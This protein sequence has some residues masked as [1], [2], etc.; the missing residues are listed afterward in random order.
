MPAVPS[1]LFDA[2]AGRR[3][4]GAPVGLLSALRAVPDPRARRGRRYECAALLAVA[5]AAVL[6][7]ARSFCAIGEWA[8]DA[9]LEVLG[10]LGVGDTAPDEKTIRVVCEAVDATALA[11]AMAGW[12]GN[13]ARR[14]G[15]RRVI[16]VDGKT[17]RGARVKDT[18]T[19]HL[20]AAFEHTS[21]IVV[22]QVQVDGK[23]NEI[24]SFAPLLDRV[25]IA[26]TV[27]TADALHTQ[28]AHAEYLHDRGADWLLTVKNNRP[29]LRAELAAL[30]WDE[31]DIAAK[32]FD[33]GH[34]RQEQRLLK[35]V[36]VSRGISFPHAAQAIQVIRRT[37]P[38]AGG[39]WHT[40]TVYAITSMTAERVQGSELNA[41]LRRHWAVENELHWV[42]DVTF[43]EDASRVRTGE[44]P[45]VMATLRNLAISL[46][47][48]LGQANVAAW[49]RR[50][51]RN[52]ARPIAALNTS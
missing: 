11:S 44:G 41:I 36:T 19:P 27:V 17:T 21:G 35:V 40:E 2:L 50:N 51:A 34:G 38:L 46:A 33:R 42:R 28:N 37:R 52:A 23:S 31:V 9:P 4:A 32:S 24:T 43:G 49:L 48:L 16:A 6:A 30:P 47:H 15:G 20:L 39:R 25:D 14:R 26:G 10:M 8:A 22:G 13:R 45:A 12:L 7:G 18:T 29:K 3:I 1:S 5:A